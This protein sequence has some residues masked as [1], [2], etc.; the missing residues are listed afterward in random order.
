MLNWGETGKDFEYSN[1]QR[2]QRFKKKVLHMALL[3]PLTNVECL[4]FSHRRVKALPQR[5]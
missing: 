4:L 5:F 1:E 3:F 2:L